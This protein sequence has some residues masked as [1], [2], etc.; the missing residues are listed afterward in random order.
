MHWEWKNCPT[1]W[2]GEYQG[3]SKKPTV[4]LEAVASNDM[5]IW[6]HFFGLPGSV[7]DINVL[8][9]SPLFNDMLH[10]TAPQVRYTIN[11]Q[12]Y[13]SGYY[14]AD[15]IYP[16]YATFVKT[17]PNPQSEKEKLFAK[18]QEARRKAVERAFGNLQGKFHILVS[19][20]RLWHLD[21]L[22]RVMTA[23]IILNN[24]AVEARRQNAPPLPSPL[25]STEPVTA[26]LAPGPTPAVMPVSLGPSGERFRA[27]FQNIRNNTLHKKLQENLIEHLWQEYGNGTIE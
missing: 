13:N 1:A 27:A 3:R 24:M 17:I 14:L 4:I 8:D 9:R 22:K 2:H 25:P 21:D 19:P 18:F 23:C 6:H 26:T 15:G 11:G 7:N 5:W 12:A 16:P 20:G 10:C